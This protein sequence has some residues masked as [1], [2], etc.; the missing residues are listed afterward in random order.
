[1]LIDFSR[2]KKLSWVIPHKTLVTERHDGES[3][4]EGVE[5]RFLS[6]ASQHMPKDEDRLTLTLDTEILQG[7]LG[8]TGT[9]ELTGRAGSNPR[10][11]RPCCKNITDRDLSID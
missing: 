1:M 7:S 2:K 8:S 4:I 3:V 6:L 11:T 5:R 10:H 9:G